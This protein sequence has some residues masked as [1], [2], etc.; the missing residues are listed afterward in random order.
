MDFNNNQYNGQNNN[1]YNGQNN[2]QYNGQNNQQPNYYNNVRKPAQPNR[3][4]VMTSFILGIAALAST[5]LMTVYI[6]IIL[7]GIAIMMAILSR[8][9]DG[10][11]QTKAKIGMRL[12]ICAMVANFVI[13]G[14]TTY[15]LLRNPDILREYGSMYND[16]YEQLY[17]ESF[18]EIMEDYYNQF[19][20]TPE[21]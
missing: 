19:P 14:F 8:N 1:P 12:A 7:G 13:L 3:K 11:F 9:R 6:P 15:Y 21:D 10:I 18:D 2:N 17:G 16:V 20:E 4:L 5:I